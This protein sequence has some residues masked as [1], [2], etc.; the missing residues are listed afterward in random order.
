MDYTKLMINIVLDDV[1]DI[2]RL[3]SGTTA[4]RILSKDGTSQEVTL[5]I[6]DAER[7]LWN[8]NV[9]EPADKVYSY[10]MQAGK[11]R[12][13]T[14]QFDAL[15]I[16]T[17]DVLG[18]ATA[19]AATVTVKTND[20]LPTGTSVYALV[21]TNGGA[22]HGTATIVEST[23]VITYTSAAYYVGL[24]QLKYQVTDSDGIV[25]TAN[26]YIQVGAT[27]VAPATVS[28][29]NL[30][31]YILY[32][33]K[34]WDTNLSKP[35]ANLIQRA[36]VAGGLYEWYKAAAQ[37]DIAKIYE[38]EYITALEGAKLNINKRAYTLRRPHVTF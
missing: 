9:R 29:G 14:Y 24:D 27:A 28:T 20:N 38:Q 37:Y 25:S 12:E 21:G 17:H 2:A 30:V 3:K 15:P 22:Q 1:F 34:D 5:A 13:G 31:K 23:G 19:Q 16:A 11:I 7:D 18:A 36:I 6:T 26:V 10:L 35:L 4:S 33:N 8:I 32:I